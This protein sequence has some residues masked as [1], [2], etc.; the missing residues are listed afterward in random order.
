MLTTELHPWYQWFKE[1]GVLVKSSDF[2]AYSE[3]TELNNKQE[4]KSGTL[5]FRQAVK[6][7]GCSL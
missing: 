3:H 5:L 2:H 6:Q 4:K 7:C 1:N